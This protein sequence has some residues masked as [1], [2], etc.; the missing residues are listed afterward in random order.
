MPRRF[1]RRHHTGKCKYNRPACIGFIWD[2]AFINWYLASTLY[3]LYLV[4]NNINIYIIILIA[5]LER[6]IPAIDIE[7]L[8]VKPPVL[9]YI[10]PH[11]HVVSKFYFP[12]T[13]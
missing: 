4:S 10:D 2:E 1:A 5:N 13:L 9:K 12:K 8:K 11:E 3:L 6:A 7:E